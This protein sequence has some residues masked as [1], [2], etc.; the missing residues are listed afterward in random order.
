MMPRS[1]SV[2]AVVLFDRTIGRTAFPLDVAH[3]D[4][5]GT[6]GGRFMDG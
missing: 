3:P 6:L 2:C 1:E 5:R 4:G